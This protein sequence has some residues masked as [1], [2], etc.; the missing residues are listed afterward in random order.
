MEA[1]QFAF[2]F[3]VLMMLVC[4]ELFVL[5]ISSRQ[6]VTG[7]DRGASAQQPVRF[8]APRDSSCHL[9]V[10]WALGALDLS[11]QSEPGAQSVGMSGEYGQGWQGRRSTGVP[12]TSGD[13]TAWS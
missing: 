8:G 5:G 13:R 6:S 10:F 1:L 7:R 4:L 3:S 12:L 11:Q 9:C 2:F